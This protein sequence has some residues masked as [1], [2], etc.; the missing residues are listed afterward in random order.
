M[1]IIKEGKANLE[2][3]NGVFYNPKMKQLRDI[4]VAFLN[5]VE[6]DGDKLVD[7]TSAS[8]VRG[9]RYGLETKCKDITFVDIDFDACRATK[10]N[11]KRNRVKG[12]VINQ[13]FQDFAN[14]CNE[15][16]DVV[17]VDPFGTPTP[18]VYDALKI[19]K[20]GTILMVTATDTAVLCGAQKLA[21]SK[22]YASIPLHT[23]LCHEAGLRILINYI[24][25]NAA[26]FDFGIEVLL[27]IADMHYMRVFVRLKKGAKKAFE[28]VKEVGFVDY[29][30]KCQNFSLSYGLSAKGKA[31]CEYCGY[32]LQRAGPMWIGRLNDKKTIKKMLDQSD[33]PLDGYSSKLLLTTYQELDTQFFYSVP[34]LTKHLGIGSVSANEVVKKL[35]EKHKATRTFF[36]DFGIKTNAG[37]SEVFKAIKIIAKR[38]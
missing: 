15:K 3:A 19:C 2:I 1:E 22:M 17:D 21:C 18:F 9:I 11:A 23:E 35:S 34:K 29:C 28:S 38:R 20:N 16:F 10:K 30:T 14:V 25:R 4:S 13:S 37:I 5:A 36:D 26:Q 6:I 27:S 32:A 12:R 8:G 24:L 31:D 7:A 33:A